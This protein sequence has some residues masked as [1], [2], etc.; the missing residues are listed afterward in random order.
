MEAQM[1]KIVLYFGSLFLV[2]V[3]LG[4]TVGH[5]SA[6]ELYDDSDLN[7][8]APKV[9][10]VSPYFNGIPAGTRISAQMFVQSDIRGLECVTINN[11]GSVVCTFPKRFGGENATLYLTVGGK[12]LIFYVR[13]PHVQVI[14]P[15]PAPA[16][17]PII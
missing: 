11:E 17:S 13:I 1:K 10:L 8:A 4:M 7:G 6:S 9:Y 15:A 14:T 12:M 5:A 3:M 16:P 2:A